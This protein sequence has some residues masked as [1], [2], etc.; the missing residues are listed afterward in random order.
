MRPV[1]W[2]VKC[3]SE[4]KFVKDIRIST[5]QLGHKHFRRGNSRPPLIDDFAGGK[6]LVVGSDG[7]KA[8]FGE[9]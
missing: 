9:G 5:C 3:V 7:S 2:L 4:A 8:R 1:H 6:D